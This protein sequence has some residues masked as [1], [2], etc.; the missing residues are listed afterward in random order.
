MYILMNDFDTLIINTDRK[1]GMTGET[2]NI[3]FVGVRIQFSS[4]CSV[5]QIQSYLNKAYHSEREQIVIVSVIKVFEEIC[6]DSLDKTRSSPITRSNSIGVI[7]E[8]CWS[9]L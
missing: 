8:P 5:F 9:S 1:I 3:S 4:T 6:Y 7:I 2:Q